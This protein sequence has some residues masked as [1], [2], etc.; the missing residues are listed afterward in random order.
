ELQGAAGDRGEQSAMRRGWRRRREV[1]AK[2]F[3][4]CKPAG[5]KPNGGR[6]HVALAAG[7]LTGKAQARLGV[8]PQG[9]IEELGRVEEGVAVKAAEARE[10]G[11]LEPRN[12]AED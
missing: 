7:D 4:G 8:E 5:E 6:F 3:G 12:S 9:A 2:P 10:F 1:M 11:P